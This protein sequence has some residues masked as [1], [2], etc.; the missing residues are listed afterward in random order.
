MAYP[1]DMIRTNDVTAMKLAGTPRFQ[2]VFY[3]D[4]EYGRFITASVGLF[5][6]DES[7]IFDVMCKEGQI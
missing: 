7:F 6:E 1:R 5:S 2:G 4:T 3:V